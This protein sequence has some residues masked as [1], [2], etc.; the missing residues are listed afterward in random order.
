MFG[1]R[2]GFRHFV[3]GNRPLVLP[4]PLPGQPRLSAINAPPQPAWRGQRV[5]RPACGAVR[6]LRG[7]GRPACGAAWRGA[8]WCGAVVVRGRCSQWLGRLAR[9]ARGSQH[10]VR[11]GWPARCGQRVCEGSVRRGLRC[12]LA[13]C[14]LAWCG[15]VRCGRGAGPVQAVAACEVAAKCAIWQ[16]VIYISPRLCHTVGSANYGQGGGAC[17][18]SLP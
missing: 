5:A 16:R 7:W 17:W 11:P 10:A 14:C 12:C 1:N 8:A 15:L 18:G 4:R 3:G 6:G 2:E 9:P 13:R